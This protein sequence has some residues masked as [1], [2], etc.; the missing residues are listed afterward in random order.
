MSRVATPAVI[1]AAKSTP[2][3][4]DSVPDQLAT[5][6]ERAEHEGREVVDVF[7]EDDVSG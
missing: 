1:Y 3:E 5:C 2:D 7:S 4:H 6:R